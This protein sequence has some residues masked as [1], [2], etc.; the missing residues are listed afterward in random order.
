MFL[1]K[2]NLWISLTD[3]RETDRLMR[4]RYESRFII[5]RYKK[6][7]QGFWMRLKRKTTSPR[8]S[9]WR[10]MAKR[11]TDQWLVASSASLSVSVSLATGCH[12]SWICTSTQFTTRYLSHTITI[13]AR[14]S[15]GTYKRTCLP[16]RLKVLLLMTHWRPWEFSFLPVMV[17]ILCPQ[18]IAMNITAMKSKQN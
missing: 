18:S 9:A 12:R 1:L 16:T 4:D 14:I 3:I 10:R 7:L 15:S 13:T 5:E 2:I 11:H 17:T 8:E 6:C